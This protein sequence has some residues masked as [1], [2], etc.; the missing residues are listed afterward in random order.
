M[1]TKTLFPTGIFNMVSI[2]LERKVPTV[3]NTKFVMGKER[4]AIT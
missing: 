1:E 3:W 2:V 4:S